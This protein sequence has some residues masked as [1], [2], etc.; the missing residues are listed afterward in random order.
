M[1]STSKSALN[2]FLEER[3]AYIQWFIIFFF[4]DE[5]YEK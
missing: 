3:V 5:R 2:F 4:S 1:G